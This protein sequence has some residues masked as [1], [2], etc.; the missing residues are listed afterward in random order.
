MKKIIFFLTAISLLAFHGCQKD[1]DTIDNRITITDEVSAAARTATIS[2]TVECPV[3]IT[4]IELWIDSDENF[5]NHIVHD[6]ELSDKAFSILVNELNINT[7]YYYK[8]VV[9]TAVDMAE[10]EKKNFIT[11]DGTLPSVTTA[12]VTSITTNTAVCGG[13]VTS[14]GNLD[15]TARGV[16]WST[17]P[18]PTIS[19]S[20]T[21]NGTGTGSFTSNVTGL[22]EGTTYYVRAY[23]TNSKG[24]AYGAEKSFTTLAKTL[25]Q[26]TTANVTS[27]TATTAVCG[28]NVTSDGNLD[29]TARGVCWSTSPNPTISNSK[30][31]NGTGTGSFTSNITGLTANTIYYVRAYATNSKGTAYGEEKSFTTNGSINGR[32]WVDLGLPSG[33]KW[34]TCNVGASRPHEYGNYY[35]WGETT[36]KA[37]YN[38]YNSVTYGQQMSDISGNA[39]YDAARANWGS[40]WRMP[41]KTEMEELENNCTWTWTTQSGVNGMRVT[42]PNGNS[43]FLP[44]TGYCGGS[45]HDRVG[46]LG[47]YWSST[48][49]E[50]DTNLACSLYF[51]TG[52]HYVIWGNRIPGYTVRPVSD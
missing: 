33:T 43:I 25:P 17:S 32:N 42:G 45:S 35:A 30:T 6:I 16:C 15:V 47:Y 11:Q 48:P 10:L 41:T 14:E 18:N 4:K 9:Y 51:Y 34:A 20:K 31:T 22:A 44:A 19:N 7:T 24:T 2:G 12:E 13:N 38:Q 52:R 49:N 46:E 37:S 39:T 27:I 23:A 5:S 21:T 28:G 40:T 3:N 1:P 8:Y 29:V 50:S 26:I 36:T